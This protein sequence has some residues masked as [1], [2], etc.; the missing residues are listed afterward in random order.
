MQSS[1]EYDLSAFLVIY[2]PVPAIF[3]RSVHSEKWVFHSLDLWRNKTPAVNAYVALC[4]DL[5]SC[6]RYRGLVPCL[7]ISGS[8]SQ[9]KQLV[10]TIGRQW[11]EISRRMPFRERRQE[12]HT[13]ASQ[14]VSEFTLVASTRWMKTLPYQSSSVSSLTSGSSSVSSGSSSSSSICSININKIFRET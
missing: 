7:E 2:V 12:F 4:F 8:L 1:M 14:L 13:L 10:E 9:M 11:H 3:L 5:W 6:P